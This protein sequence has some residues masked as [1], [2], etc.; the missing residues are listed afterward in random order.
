[1]VKWFEV[2]K[3]NEIE[4]KLSQAA[5]EETEEDAVVAETVVEETAETARTR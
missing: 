2:L 3:A 5:D 1:M 4:I